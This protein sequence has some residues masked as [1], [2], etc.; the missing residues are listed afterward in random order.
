[1]KENFLRRFLPRYVGVLTPQTIRPNRR[2]IE[3]FETIQLDYSLDA[4]INFKNKNFIAVP[5]APRIRS[6]KTFHQK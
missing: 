1:M 3:S 4:A 2:Y 6:Y 5:S